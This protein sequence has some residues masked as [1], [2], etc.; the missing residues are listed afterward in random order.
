MPLVK[1]PIEHIILVIM[2]QLVVWNWTNRC[3][4]EGFIFEMIAYWRNQERRLAIK[5]QYFKVNYALFL[6]CILALE[7]TC[8]R[9]FWQKARLFQMRHIAL[10]VIYNQCIH[11]CWHGFSILPRFRLQWLFLQC[12]IIAQV[13]WS[14][15][16]MY[17]NEM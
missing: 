3:V 16:T 10:V 7:S 4:L 11:T 5:V 8:E 6:V 1:S 15:V 14:L 13:I 12:S 9:M 2:V 17:I